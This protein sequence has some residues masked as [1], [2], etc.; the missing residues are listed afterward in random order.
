MRLFA[1]EKILRNLDSPTEWVVLWVDL[2][3]LMEAVGIGMRVES[4]DGQLVC[5]HVQR[6]E[7]LFESQILAVA[8]DV[9]MLQCET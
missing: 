1:L 8:V 7:D 9:N 5:R 6:H 3:G 4:I 2:A